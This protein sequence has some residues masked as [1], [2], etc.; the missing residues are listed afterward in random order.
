[1]VERLRQRGH[2]VEYHVFDDE[3]HGFT[4]RRNQIRAWEL[5]SRFLLTRLGV[6]P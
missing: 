4:K 3:G 2:P 1:M 6:E 5:A